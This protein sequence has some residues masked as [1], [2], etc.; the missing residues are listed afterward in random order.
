MG[1]KK[2]TAALMFYYLLVLTWVIL[3]K[4]Q[5]TF[6]GL[7][8]IRHINLVPLGAS[9]IVNGQIAWGEIIQNF[10][11]FIPLGIL[12]QGLLTEKSLIRK[13]VLI[14]FTSFVLELMQFVFA[15]GATDITDLIANAAGGVLG[16]G[17]TFFFSKLLKGSWR[18]CLNLTALV[19]AVLFSIFIAVLLSA[20]L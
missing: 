17:I 16:I 7:D 9:V 6:D 20:N 10:L 1:S 18:K 14:V 3:F 15:V 12:L 19:C 13:T 2:F 5:F 4:F 11:V 8:H